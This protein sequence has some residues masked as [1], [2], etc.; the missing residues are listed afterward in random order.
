VHTD[1]R[2]VDEVSVALAQRLH[3]VEPGQAGAA[4]GEA[5]VVEAVAAIE[6]PRVFFLRENYDKGVPGAWTLSDDVW[7]AY[8][9]HCGSEEAAGSKGEF[10]KALVL[11]GG[12]QIKQTQ[13]RH[14]GRKLGYEGLRRKK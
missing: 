2:L 9:A 13:P 4:E 3:R 5:R 10:F 1:K 14:T 6:S 7:K 12:A 11:W 8:V